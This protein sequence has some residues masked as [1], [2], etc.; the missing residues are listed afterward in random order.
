MTIA[1]LQLPFQIIEHLQLQK[2]IQLAA[3]GSPSSIEF[4]AATTVQRW[5]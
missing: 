4:P 3:Q 1:V 5:L 2:L